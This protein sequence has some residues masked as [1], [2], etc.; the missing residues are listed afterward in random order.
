[1]GVSCLCGHATCLACCPL[2]ASGRAPFP[3]KKFKAAIVAP[4]PVK[5]VPVSSLLRPKRKVLTVKTSC[6]PSST[7]VFHSGTTLHKPQNSPDN[8]AQLTSD[9]KPKLSYLQNLISGAAAGATVS[10]ILFPINTIKT[11]VMA[12]GKLGSIRLSSGLWRGVGFDIIGQAVTTALFF[13]TYGVVHETYQRHS[14]PSSD[15]ACGK[16]VSFNALLAEAVPSVSAS[17]LSSLLVVPNEAIRQNV[18]AH[19]Y[20]S[21]LLAFKGILKERGVGGFYRGYR[22]SL[23]RDVPFDSLQFTLYQVARNSYLAATGREQ[24][25]HGEAAVIGGGAGALTGVF[26]TPVDVIKTQRVLLA[27]GLNGG[28]NLNMLATVRSMVAKEGLPGLFKGAG[29]RAVEIA[30]GGVIFF[31]VLE[32][33]QKTLLEQKTK[34]AP[35][36]AAA[37]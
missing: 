15:T 22:Y 21:T 17:L 12:G 30:L 14:P 1:M 4:Q 23:M 18:Q 25:S 8:G 10:S 5:K 33:V 35:I 11:R 16:S 19:T 9:V 24:L 27:E 37:E 34:V 28:K 3:R 31:S 7:A 26:T 6:E 29:P 13:G 32:Q 36:L 2:D 20:P